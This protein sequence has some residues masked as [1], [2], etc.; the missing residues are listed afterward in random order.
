MDP[1]AAGPAALNTDALS[2]DCYVGLDL[3]SSGCRAVAIDAHRRVLA[4]ARTALPPSRRGPAGGSEQDPSDWWQA[5]GETLRR[6]SAQRP[7]RVRALS[8]D[9]TSSSLLLCGPD[10]RPLG[11]ALMYDDRR[12]R[13]QAK[14]LERLAPRESPTQ[15]P[16]SALAKL[17]YLLE[18]ADTR[19]AAHALHQADW[20][21]GKLMQRFGVADENNVLKLG[22]DPA[23]R[24]WPA[25][26]A[27]L[28]LPRDLLPRVYPVGARLGRIAAEVAGSLGLD[29]DVVLVAGT[30]DSNAATLAAGLSGPGDAVT[31]LGTTLVLKLYSDKPLLS[32][33]YGIYS[34]RFRDGWLTG[35]A[36]NSGGGVLRQFFDD[37]EI[38]RL[39]AQIDPARTLG[40][41][42]YP[43]P[44]VGERFPRSD[45]EM[46][47]RLQPRPDNRR[48]FL[49]AIMEGIADIEAE[50]YRRLVA[51]GAP[52]PRRV[53]TSGGGAH[54]KVWSEMRE[55]R[56]GVP[57]LHAAHTEAA[58]GC[59]L[60]ARDA[61]LGPQRRP[62]SAA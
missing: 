6:L 37:A 16:G 29:E 61:M 22:Y 7:G 3:G 43:L 26:I 34:H 36:S 47:P 31:S 55:R 12:A 30:T 38:A 23:T 9:G 56:L 54:N 44:G 58:Y 45:P 33:Q 19:G 39:S 17:L 5:V 42:Y 15:G 13:A 50:G 24:R 35:G 51:L 4:E 28:N 14:R 49:H 46:L 59:A 62:D 48:D 53:F 52:A 2:A 8:V 27:R 21:N 57:V 20:I 25:W 18:H 40:L 32:A 11:P 1:A 10:G 60:L 41:G